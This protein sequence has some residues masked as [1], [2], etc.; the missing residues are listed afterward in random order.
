[1]QV[2]TPD[3]LSSRG[4]K[5]VL[6]CVAEFEQCLYRQCDDVNYYVLVIDGNFHEDVLR[7]IEKIYENAGWKR[8]K[9][10]ISRHAKSC[11]S[12]STILELWRDLDDSKVNSDQ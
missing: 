4:T 12:G 11:T 3:D 2:T 7:K 1:M 5:M 10:S 8:A 9:C 6:S